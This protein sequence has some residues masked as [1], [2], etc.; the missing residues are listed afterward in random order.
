MLED[1]CIAKIGFFWR[2]WVARAY[3]RER[4]ANDSDSHVKPETAYIS[5]K[6]FGR[7]NLIEEHWEF[8][9]I[10]ATAQ[11][12]EICRAT[13]RMQDCQDV[14]QDILAFA[15]LRI[16]NYDSARSQPK[17]YINMLIKYAKKIIMR[18]H[19]RMKK[20]FGEIITENI[21]DHQ[22]RIFDERDEMAGHLKEWIQDMEEGE[23]KDICAKLFIEQE[24]PYK[25]GIAFGK[26]K[27]EIISIA[28]KAMAPI[29]RDLGLIRNDA[30]QP[31][32][33]SKKRGGPP[34]GTT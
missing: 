13:G 3:A 25:V 17:T 19:Y 4:L 29:A 11:A 21:E 23:T 7:M 2:T 6:S 20:R 10:T 31:Q 26:T 5:I 28:K 33:V 18:K 1:I 24:T 8:T 27:D 9:R 22:D 34:K 30:A 14:T 12:V 16:D 32:T 15:S